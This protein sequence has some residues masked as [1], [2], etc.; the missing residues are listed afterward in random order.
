M[1][2]TPFLL[3]QK[4]EEDAESLIKDAY[5][6][7]EQL[8]QS[9]RRQATDLHNATLQQALIDVQEKLEI[10]D[11]EMEARMGA[12]T[13]ETEHRVQLIKHA[14]LSHTEQALETIIQRILS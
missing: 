6:Q 1:E 3:I 7:A 4:A 11:N 2:T 10:L 14:A 5:M 12:L 9:A 13:L 8:I